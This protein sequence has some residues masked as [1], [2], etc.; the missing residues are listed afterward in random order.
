MGARARND[1]CWFGAARGLSIE[2]VSA[3][4]LISV[5][6]LF[7]GGNRPIVKCSLCT[8]NH[9]RAELAAVR[10]PHAVFKSVQECNLD[11]RQRAIYLNLPPPPHR[12]EQITTR[13][14][15]RRRRHPLSVR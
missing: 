10:G 3:L 12:D 11:L 8:T 15:R 7:S 13:H 14:R 2:T 4:Q 5:K 1:T 6:A 9:A